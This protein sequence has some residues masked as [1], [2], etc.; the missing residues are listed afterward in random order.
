VS[1]CNHF[2]AC[3]L[4]GNYLVACQEPIGA[5]LNEADIAEAARASMKDTGE[6]EEA[7]LERDGKISVAPRK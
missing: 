1:I 4:I 5:G 3:L 7:T 6:I 2:V